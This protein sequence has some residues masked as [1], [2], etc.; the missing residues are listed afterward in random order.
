MWIQRQEH[1]Q[2]IE[3]LWL[4]AKA[5]IQKRMQGVGYQLFQSHL[6]HFCWKKMRIN[7]YELFVSFLEDV[8][9]TY[10]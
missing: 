6:N 9:N 3:R 7:S 8:Q 5:V 1:T 10:R 4:D 2:A